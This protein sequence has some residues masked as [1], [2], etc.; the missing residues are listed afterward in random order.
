M[1]RILQ[2]PPMKSIILKGDK[3]VNKIFGSFAVLI[4]IGSIGCGMN[5]RSVENQEVGENY[6]DGMLYK[7]NQIGRDDLKSLFEDINGNQYS[8]FASLDSNELPKSLRELASGTEVG[9]LE[10]TRKIE[11]YEKNYEKTP[12]P[13][14]KNSVENT[15][16][17]VLLIK[18]KNSNQIYFGV[19]KKSESI[20]KKIT[21][22]V[23]VQ[24]NKVKDFCY[25]VYI[26][27]WHDGSYFYMKE[28]VVNCN[29]AGDCKF[30][31]H[32][33]PCDY[34]DITRKIQFLMDRGAV[35]DQWLP[36]YANSQVFNNQE[37]PEQVMIHLDGVS[38]TNLKSIKFDLKFD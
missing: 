2:S 24:F 9:S 5:R 19:S 36:Y 1:A 37:V 31:L 21:K 27:P 34:D 3:I 17:R 8:V 32:R 35:C 33:E 12:V 14:I 7:E 25:Q 18:L 26:R 30:R 11:S 20:L 10:L 29:H 16:E 4:M 28:Q 22:Q 13:I 6:P 15:N 38:G 23:S